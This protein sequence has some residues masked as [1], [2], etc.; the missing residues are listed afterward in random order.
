VTVQQVR[1]A[2]ARI[3][4]PEFLATVVVGAAAAQ[5]RR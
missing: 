3:V 5:E 2:F 1:D 4:R